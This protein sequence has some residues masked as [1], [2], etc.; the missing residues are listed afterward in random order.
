MRI[1][2]PPPQGKSPL[3]PEK[4]KLILS[5]VACSVLASVIYFGVGNVQITPENATAFVN[6]ILSVS[7]LRFLIVIAD[8]LIYLITL[9]PLLVQCLF[10]V[11]FAAF[12]LIFVIYNRAFTRRNLTV[13]ML[14]REWSKE[15]KE[16]YIADGKNRLERSK[17]MVSVIIP[18]LVPIALD[19]L[20]L[21]TLPIFESILHIS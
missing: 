11:T 4:K 10:W 15:Q 16:G 20:Y 6:Q 2:N 1:F 3:S 8:H 21:F 7:F 18:I 12:L 19:A 17:W 5:M 9:L 14:P 13:A